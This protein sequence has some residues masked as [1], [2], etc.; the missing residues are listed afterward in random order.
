[1][2]PRSRNPNLRAEF[3][4]SWE[5]GTEIDGVEYA[6]LPGEDKGTGG[7]GTGGECGPSSS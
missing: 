1:M 4:N 2:V 7:E 6:F 3:W 5:A